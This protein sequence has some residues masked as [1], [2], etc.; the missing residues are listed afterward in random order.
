M[1]V[2]EIMDVIDRATEPKVMSKQAA[3]EF[4]GDVVEQCRSRMEALHEEMRNAEG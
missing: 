3:H 4:L 1:S 2:D